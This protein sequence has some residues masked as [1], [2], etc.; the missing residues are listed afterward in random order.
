MAAAMAAAQDFAAVGNAFNDGII[1]KSQKKYDDAIAKFNS[2]VELASDLKDEKSRSAMAKAK[3][4]IV[5][6]S[7]LSASAMYDAGAF[8]EAAAAL[9]SA[10]EA[11]IKYN[12][13]VSMKLIDEA[14]P[15]IIFVQG[16]S[17]ME[18]GSYE[19]A[20]VYFDRS[21]GLNPQQN[22]VL[23]A[24]GACYMKSG[25]AEKG[26]EFYEKAIKT[27]SS[28]NKSTEAAQARKAAASYLLTAGQDAK[29]QKYY[30]G[31]Y[32]YF[33]ALTKYDPQNTEGYLQMAM[34]ANLG[35]KYKSAI[36]AALQGLEIE[37]RMIQSAQLAYQL[38]YAYEQNT[39]PNQPKACEYYQKAAMTTDDGIRQH[40]KDALR[41]LHCPK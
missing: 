18:M 22:N 26:L 5:N 12:D 41:R 19:E 14:L 10:K 34:A 38:A 1:L 36:D 20:I 21:L 11:A 35:R 23:M 6:C 8:E 37:K 9:Q 13:N 28:L 15:R 39:A 32:K 31:A 2:V 4:Q 40:S 16:I 24:L 7:M 33:A 17:L 29:D 3:Q 27:A 25:N 30:D